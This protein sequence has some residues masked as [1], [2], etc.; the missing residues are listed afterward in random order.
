MCTLLHFQ[1]YRFHVAAD[2]ACF[3]S[4]VPGNTGEFQN[5][6]EFLIEPCGVGGDEG[7]ESFGNF[8]GAPHNRIIRQACVRTACS[9]ECTDGGLLC[10][11]NI[12]VFQHIERRQK[13][14][15]HRGE[16]CLCP[17]AFAIGEEAI[18]N[19]CCVFPCEL[20][21][22][23]EVPSRIGGNERCRERIAQVRVVPFFCIH[24]IVR[25]RG[26]DL[27]E[28][29]RIDAVRDEE[30]FQEFHFEHGALAFE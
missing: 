20:C 6:I 7:T 10:R 2:G 3:F 19:Q 11:V 4:Q 15:F 24:H 30:H 17:P 12:V 5:F 26:A 25:E 9:K 29:K 16:E 13:L 22:R 1:G 14:A 8:E 23:R 21:S 28:C 18:E 27:I